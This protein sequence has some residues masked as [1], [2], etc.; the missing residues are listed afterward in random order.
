MENMYR[1]CKFWGIP[2]I[3]NGINVQKESVQF[4]Y[5]F[6]FQTPIMGLAWFTLVT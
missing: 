3:T 6:Y 5:F 2:L 4:I 1:L